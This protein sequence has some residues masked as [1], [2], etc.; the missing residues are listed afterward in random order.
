MTP[1]IYTD[2]E[3]AGTVNIADYVSVDLWWA[4]MQLLMF[5]H[6]KPNDS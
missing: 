2:E 5:D 1:N 6:K 3:V 4:R